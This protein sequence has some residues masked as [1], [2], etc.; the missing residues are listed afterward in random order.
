MKRKIDPNKVK[1]FLGRAVV[2]LAFNIGMSAWLFW[3]IM[4]AT[5]LN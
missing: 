1:R 3:G 4:T 5:T 2:Y